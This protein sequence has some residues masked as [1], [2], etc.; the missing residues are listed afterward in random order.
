M[1]LLE[2]EEKK[3]FLEPLS[4]NIFCYRA[5]TYSNNLMRLAI[6]PGRTLKDIPTIQVMRLETRFMCLCREISN[7]KSMRRK[8]ETE[9]R[10]FLEKQSWCPGGEAQKN[11]RWGRIK[12]RR[13]QKAFIKL[14]HKV[15]CDLKA[16]SSP[17]LLCG[18]G[19]S[20]GTV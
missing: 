20:S 8:T 19:V 15:E 2:E 3:S 17:V 13:S 11:Q 18:R 9:E 16:I 12:E 6:Q 1:S 7:F 14:A 5:R 4:S 10:S